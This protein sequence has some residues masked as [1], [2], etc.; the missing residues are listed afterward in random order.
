VVKDSLRVGISVEKFY[1]TEF[2][3]VDSDWVL[4]CQPQLHQSVQKKQ[5]IQ[6]Q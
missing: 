5:K 2:Y 4:M 1:E 6:H 3:F